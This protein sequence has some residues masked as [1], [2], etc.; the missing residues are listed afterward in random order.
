MPWSRVIEIGT[1]SGII[2]TGLIWFGSRIFVTKKEKEGLENNCKTF[3]NDCQTRLCVKI[4]KLSDQI[5]TDKLDSEI[6]QNGM[7]EKLAKRVA[8]NRDMV[9]LHYA[10]VKGVLGSIQGQLV[11]IERNLD[12]EKK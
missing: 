7:E 3:R 8:E 10:E 12:R 6:H 5:K 11:S 2:G 1:A 9:L 4:D